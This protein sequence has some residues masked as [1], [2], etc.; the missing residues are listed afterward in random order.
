MITLFYSNKSF[1]KLEKDILYINI[2]FINNNNIELITILEYLKNIFLLTKENNNKYFFHINIINIYVLN[3]KSI[4][5]IL[6]VL[7]ELKNILISNL[8]STC[9][10]IKSNYLL[11]I[12]KPI[13][14]EYDNCRPFKICNNTEEAMQFFKLNKL[15]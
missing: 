1:I 5:I 6:L 13:L 3:K 4:N 14:N 10:I 2:E 9:L 11:T 12:I 15:N 8:H 7:N